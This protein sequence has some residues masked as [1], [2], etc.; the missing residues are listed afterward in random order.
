MVEG[1][2]V[3]VLDYNTKI[4]H[5]VPGQISH[6]SGNNMNSHGC[7]TSVFA[8]KQFSNKSC[9]LAGKDRPAISN[10]DNSKSSSG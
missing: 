10:Q 8:R 6:I 1:Q 9:E 3:R 4:S 5:V 2:W 7:A